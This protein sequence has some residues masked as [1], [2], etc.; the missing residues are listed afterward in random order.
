MRAHLHIPLILLLAAVPAAGLTPRLVK[1]INPVSAPESS[2]PSRFI[3]VGGLTF[4]S[5][6]DSDTGRELWRTD[7]TVAGTF[8]VADA[9]PGECS[10]NPGFM[11]RSERS[12][13]FRVP[14]QAISRFDT[15]SELWVTSGLPADTFRLTEKLRF[16]RPI[17]RTRLWIASQGLFYFVASD[18]EHGLELWRSDGTPAGTFMAADVRSGGEG[19]NPAELTELNGKLFFSANDGVH[20]PGLWTSDGTERGTRLVLDPAPGLI[21]HDGPTLL[22]AAGKNLFFSAPAAGRAAQLWKSDGTARGTAPVTNFQAG[23]VDTAALGK[24]LLFVVVDFVKGQELWVSDGT[25]RGTRALTSFVGADAFFDDFLS[26]DLL[27]PQTSVGNRLIF[28]VDDGVHGIELWTTDGTPKGTRLLKDVCPGV[29]SSLAIQQNV[30]AVSGNSLFFSATDGEHGAEPWVTDGT[31]AGTHIVQDLCPGSCNSI[32]LLSSSLVFF[33]AEAGR[34]FL[35]ATPNGNVWQLWRSDG[36]AP[37]TVQLTSFQR[38][39]DLDSG[40][41]LGGAFLFDARDDQHGGEL[42]RSGGTPESTGLLADLNTS[43][44]GGSAPTS[45]AAAGGKLYFIAD[46]GLHGPELWTSDGTDA[47]TVLV[48][49]F[50]PGG[51]PTSRSSLSAAAE[52]DGKLVFLLHLGPPDN[53][54]SL[55]RTD[56]TETG[57]FRLGPDVRIER[58][59]ELRAVGNQV[60]F[61]A[62]DADHGKELWATDGA[63]E[64]TRLV[65]DLEPGDASSSPAD[66]TAFR[67]KLYFT[68]FTADTGR[69]LWQSD[70]TPGG[71]ALVKDINPHGGSGPQF[72]T[73]HA[74]RLYFFA[75]DG[76]PRTELWSSDG[77]AGGTTLA[78]NLPE[79][80]SLFPGA[81]IST[82]SRLF[83]SGLSSSGDDVLWVSD[84][85]AAGS[86]RIGSILMIDNQSTAAFKGDLYFIARDGYLWKSDGTEVGTVPFHDR[87]GQPIF[88]QA[89][90][91]VSSGQLFF[92]T[93]SQGELFQSD[94][95]PEGTFPLLDLRAAGKPLSLLE[96][97]LAGP[98]LFFQKW[99]RATGAELWALE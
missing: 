26:Q 71:T 44:V 5:A 90:F 57:T 65:K 21:V 73:E 80:V 85:T 7:G 38:A 62:S 89:S 78:A 48:H 20:G 84:G 56:G 12:Y 77:T 2:A 93:F 36:T 6:L 87:N 14:E 81:M 43:D 18:G 33:S 49:E 50:F 3:T 10:G 23:V 92:T 79:T 28:P 4:F 51:G 35:Q 86:K 82:G 30:L 63:T 59:A 68:A 60:F 91:A 45:L 40:A 67:G 55:W 17:S 54:D 41:V 88:S 94:G 8:Q 25:S 96:L 1:D 37:G 58:P 11:G 24:R 53:S 39:D 27:L 66:L 42:W 52:V 70:G 29:C 47:G 75:G 19:S 76:E 9:C 61:V 22:R 83:F 64:G 72:L 34:V 95:T 97:K 13:F 31:S 32:P 74:G 69:E 98:R 15:L 16:P 46:D 99:D